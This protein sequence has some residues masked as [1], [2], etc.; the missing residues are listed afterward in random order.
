MEIRQNGKTAV[1]HGQSSKTAT[2]YGQN[3]K[4][5]LAKHGRQRSDTNPKPETKPAQPR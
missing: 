1:K 2:K 3:S 4:T 5:A